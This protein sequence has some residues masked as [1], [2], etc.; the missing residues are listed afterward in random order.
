[1]PSSRI[2]VIAAILAPFVVSI[3]A[4]GCKEKQK[5][6]T[7]DETAAKTPPRPHTPKDPRPDRRPVAN[8]IKQIKRGRIRVPS[9]HTNV[10]SIPLD[11]YYERYAGPKSAG[12][13]LVVL[14]GGPGNPMP[15]ENILKRSHLGRV[16][17]THYDIVYFEQRGAG[18]SLR[19]E[20]KK[21]AFIKKNINRYTM[22]QYVADL[23]AV[24]KKTFGAKRKIT[25]IGS[26]WGGY[27]GLAYALAFPKNIERVILGSF[28]AT[29][30]STTDICANFDR[31]LTTAAHEDPSLRPVMKAF[32]SAVKKGKIL[33]PGARY[34]LKLSD[35]IELASP[36]AVKARYRRLAG[37]LTL[38]LKGEKRGL[39]FMQSL[40]LDGTTRVTMGGSLAARA[41]YCEEMVDK[42][43]ID[44]LLARPKSTLYCSNKEFLNALKKSCLSFS[45]NKKHFDVSQRLNQLQAPALVFAGKLDPLVPWQAT[46]ATAAR[47]PDATFLLIDGGHTPIKAGGRC[48]ADAVNRFAQGK[49]LRDHTCSN[50]SA[51]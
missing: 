46:A 10:D 45:K 7:D 14:H 26:S 49:P 37:M 2:T 11:L 41:T 28:E 42:H 31:A 5:P 27:L 17:L 36:F 29:A 4:A 38:I 23:E 33:V 51:R 8:E 32:R 16:L 25:I 9:D 18:R 13:P 30:R 44:K 3:G 6:K 40:K 34:V 1:M 15:M 22:S 43:L 12:K 39:K 35:V 48:F 47:M 19:P 24:R 50:K 21:H 20:E